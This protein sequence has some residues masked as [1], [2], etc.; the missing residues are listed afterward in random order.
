MEKIINP[1]NGLLCDVVHLKEGD[2]V[3]EGDV[4]RSTEIIDSVTGVGRL[5]AVTD[6]V[7]GTT[8]GATC[9]VSFMRLLVTDVE[10]I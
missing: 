1:I 3:Q 8:I 10:Q 7:A 4:Y 9:N 6:V 2:V 5:F